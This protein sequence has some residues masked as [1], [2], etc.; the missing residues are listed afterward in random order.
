M[1]TQWIR[2]VDDYSTNIEN[3]LVVLVRCN[4]PYG[5]KEAVLP[6]GPVR[7]QKSK[8]LQSQ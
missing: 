5:G 4:V 6:T 2:F 7:V 8:E 3:K 1:I